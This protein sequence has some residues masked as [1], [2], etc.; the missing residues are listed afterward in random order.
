MFFINLRFNYYQTVPKLHREIKKLTKDITF[1]YKV[2]LK[3]ESRGMQL[4]VCIFIW[5]CR[6][7]WIHGKMWCFS[8]IWGLI[9]I[10]LYL[11]FMVKSKNW[12]K[13]ITFWYKVRL[14]GESHGIQLFVHIFIWSCQNRWIRGKMWCFSSIWGSIMIK[15]YLNFM[16]KSKNSQKGI[17]FWDKVRLKGESCRIQFLSVFS[18]GDSE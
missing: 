10:K 8:S 18:F 9:M 1:W 7:G 15:L 14:N 5:S 13:D 2:R 17:T 11:N 4:F 3:G 12:Q 6:N 16:V